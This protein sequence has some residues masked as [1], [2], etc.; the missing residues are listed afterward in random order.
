MK[1]KTGQKL[2]FVGDSITDAGRTNG[3]GPFGQGYVSFLRGLVMA[4]HPDLTLNFANRGVS[5]NTI[6]DL[7][8][9]WEEDV[10]NERP[11]HLFVMIGINDVW[12]NFAAGEWREFHVPL[13][14]F[15][16]TYEK[17]LQRSR[18][19][20]IESIRLC[21]SFFVEPNREEPMRQLCERYNAAVQEFAD[22]LAL[23]FTDMQAV[24]DRL[25]EYQHPMTI[26]HDRVHPELHGHLAMAE[27]VCRTLRFFTV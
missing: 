6:R 4:R 13:N 10:L 18:E 25:L 7:A 26:A 1:V 22:K 27:E 5:G 14:E 15:T 9:R 16:E 11:D 12:R 17:L 3:F 21:G 8:A 24:F 19:A 20:G 23:P 2:L